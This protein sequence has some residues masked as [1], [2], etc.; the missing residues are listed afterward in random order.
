[1]SH[2][3][4]TLGILTTLAALSLGLATTSPASADTGASAKDRRFVLDWGG[5]CLE[6]GDHNTVY[7]YD[8]H[9][10]EHQTWRLKAV[11]K[12]KS[13]GYYLI[14][15]KHT[16]LCLD[17]RNGSPQ[18]WTPVITAY[19]HGAKWQQ[20][21][22]HEAKPGKYALIARHSQKCLDIRHSGFGNPN[23]SIAHQWD[24]HYGGN[25]LWIIH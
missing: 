2:I 15:N 12:A 11:S 7:Q 8:C 20:W 5:R 22:L 1:M 14:V 18:N 3:R 25:Q 19:C 24:C 23:G 9:N 4:K 6:N 13:K 21:R 17:V 16:G 10:G